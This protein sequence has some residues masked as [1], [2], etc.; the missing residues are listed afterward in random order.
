MVL[1]LYSWHMR[2]ASFAA[3]IGANVAAKELQ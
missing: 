3:I 2:L 1:L